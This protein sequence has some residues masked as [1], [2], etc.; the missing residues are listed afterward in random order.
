[1]NLENRKENS[2]APNTDKRS[3]LKKVSLVEKYELKWLTG[4]R[5][6]LYLVVVIDT[7]LNVN[8]NITCWSQCLSNVLHNKICFSINLYYQFTENKYLTSAVFYLYI[9]KTCC[10]PVRTKYGQLI[11]KKNTVNQSCH[12]KLTFYISQATAQVVSH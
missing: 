3:G 9:P 7:R 10:I 4:G 1:M 12:M 2:K 11:Q 6:G 5:I 8:C